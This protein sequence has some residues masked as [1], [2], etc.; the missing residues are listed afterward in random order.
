ME[1][2]PALFVGLYRFEREVGEKWQ[3]QSKVFK[4]PDERMA[5]NVGGVRYETTVGVLKK[6]RFS[7]LAGIADGILGEE[8]G[9]PFIDR[10]WWIF[11]YILAFLRH[12]SLPDNTGL[13]RQL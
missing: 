12:G 9:T 4:D 6:D 10:D 8:I 3:P 2:F 7:L 5:I 11:R 1:Y 13:L